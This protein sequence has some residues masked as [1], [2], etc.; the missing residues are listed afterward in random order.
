MKSQKLSTHVHNGYIQTFTGRM[1]NPL[2][3]TAADVD[4]RDIAHALSNLCRWSGHT[5]RFYSVAE[6]S[7][8]VWATVFHEFNGTKRD[9]LYALLHDAAEAYLIDVPTPLKVL[10]QF[11][12][13]RETEARL[14]RVIYGAFGLDPDGEPAIVKRADI[15]MRGIES[16]DL[17]GGVCAQLYASEIP[18]T[19]HASLLPTQFV[20][21]EEMYLRVTGRAIRQGEDAYP[22]SVVTRHVQQAAVG[23]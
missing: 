8:H 11:D 21:V 15:A 20:N 17:M 19:P 10:P 18:H 1:V 7:L 14:E 6:H 2:T 12:W 22:N 4:I 16:R 13:Y 5:K 23:A 9:G 3:M